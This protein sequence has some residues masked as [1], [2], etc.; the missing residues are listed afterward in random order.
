MSGGL[1]E[2]VINLLF[3]NIGGEKLQSLIEGLQFIV[4][5]SAHFTAYAVLGILSFITLVTYCL[6]LMAKCGLS[7]VICALYAVSDEY[8]QT[9]IEG[10]SGELRDVI[11]DSSGALAGII[12]SLII[13]KIIQ[14]I[15]NRRSR[16]MNKKQY[17]ELT[18]N[19]TRRLNS[20]NKRTEELTEENRQLTKEN[21]FLNEELFKLKERIIALENSVIQTKNDTEEVLEE[22]TAPTAQEPELSEGIKDGAK[23]I[24]KIVVSSAKYC[25]DLTGVASVPNAKELVNLILGRTEV[26]KAEILRLSA[27]DVDHAERVSAMEKELQEAED[28]FKS[29]MAQKN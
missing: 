8:H 13:Y 27:L 7:L 17:I 28:Y 2:K 26:A 23:I 16:K 19:L 15:K 11:I 9:F 29:V 6:P 14:S 18:E 12:L 25:N 5:K 4:R 21:S 10:R 22:N 1:I 3:P 20:E 24:G